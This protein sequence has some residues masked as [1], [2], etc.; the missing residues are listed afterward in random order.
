MYIIY[1]NIFEP[2]LIS[3]FLKADVW[4]SSVN[5]S[6]DLSLGAVSAAILSAAGPQIQQEAKHKKPNGINPGEFLETSSGSLKARGVQMILH[7]SINSWPGS[8]AQTDAVDVSP[9]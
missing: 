9:F 1:H 6:L 3:I 5:S 7:T 8:S 2:K 4:V